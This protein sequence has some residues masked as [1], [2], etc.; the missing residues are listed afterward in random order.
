LGVVADYSKTP[1][2]VKEKYHPEARP[3]KKRTEKAKP[4]P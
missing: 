4:N 1:T 3:G 2:V